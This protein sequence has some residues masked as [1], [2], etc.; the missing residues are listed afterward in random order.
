MS[1]TFRPLPALSIACAILL[2][3][4]V[5]LGVWQVERL[6]W[7]LG[8]IA[9]VNR[10]MV[11]APV[12]LNQA[13]AMSS[14]AQ[15]RRVRLEGAFDNGKETYVFG[16]GV[17]GAPVFH[18]IVP[19]HLKD[20]RVVLVDRGIV[21]RDMRDPATRVRGLKFG[22]VSVIGVWRTPDA[23]GPFTPKPDPAKRIWYSHDVTGIARSAGIIPAAPVIVEVD[24]TPN[25]GGWPRGGQTQA[26]FRNEH[27][28][29]AITWFLMAAALMGVYLAYHASR[30]RLSFGK[31]A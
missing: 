26:N 21:P 20:G 12:T 13:L 25:P 8:L 15:Y 31:K 9:D 3:A 23:A 4:L 5:S 6:E 1:V 10:N 22:Q 18:V 24:A 14:R 2:V 27:L 29:Y 16:T 17:E 11:A 7:K 28:Q 30:G 19:F